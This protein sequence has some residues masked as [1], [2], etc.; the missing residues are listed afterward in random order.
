MYNT[1]NKKNKLIWVIFTWNKTFESVLLCWQ[2]L[3]YS[4]FTFHSLLYNIKDKHKFIKSVG[5]I[6]SKIQLYYA[7]V[8]KNIRNVYLEY[9]R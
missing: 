1:C 2:W 4:K 9:D 5:I 7:D 6:L 3:N 8:D